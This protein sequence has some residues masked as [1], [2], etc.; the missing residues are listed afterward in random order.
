MPDG[1]VFN[2]MEKAFAVWKILRWTEWRWP[3]DVVLRQESDLLE[4]IA[5]LQW[6]YKLMKDSLSPSAGTR[7]SVGSAVPTRP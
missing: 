3:P 4:D 7:G 2:D 5:Q 6:Y 1:L